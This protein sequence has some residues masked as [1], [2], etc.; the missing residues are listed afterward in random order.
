LLCS[1]EGAARVAS[2]KIAILNNSNDGE[3]DDA[4]REI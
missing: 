3:Y 4:R 1:I 2:S